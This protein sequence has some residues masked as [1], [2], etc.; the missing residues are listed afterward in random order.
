VGISPSGY[1]CI[2]SAARALQSRHEHHP[3]FVP[4]NK[5]KQMKTIAIHRIYEK[6]N[7]ESVAIVFRA[8]GKEIVKQE[9]S[10]FEKWVA[11]QKDITVRC[12]FA[13]PSDRL[14]IALTEMPNVTVKVANWHSTGIAKNLKPEEI[15]DAVES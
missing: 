8:D 2:S 5:E 11:K 6:Q 7:G 4:D 3:C 15:A 13:N 1:E 12:T 14:L 9:E 10:A